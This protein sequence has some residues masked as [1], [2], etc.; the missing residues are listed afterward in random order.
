MHECSKCGLQSILP[1][2]DPCPQHPTDKTYEL[3]FSDLE[4]GH[5]DLGFMSREDCRDPDEEDTRYARFL[6]EKGF[7]HV[8]VWDG[9]A[10][11]L[12]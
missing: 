4:I 8:R 9:K 7:K 11:V 1:L 6:K 3:L 10:R 12:S 2:Q 5:A